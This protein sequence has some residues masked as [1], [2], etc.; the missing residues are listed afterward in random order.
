MICDSQ[1]GRGPDCLRTKG[2]DITYPACSILAHGRVVRA[3]APSI[4]SSTAQFLQYWKGGQWEW[5]ED[6]LYANIAKW[7]LRLTRTATF[8]PPVR[9]G[10]LKC[11]R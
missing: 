9:A 10:G 8:S 3:L 1:S 5:I 4:A 2:A 11:M 6:D 7:W